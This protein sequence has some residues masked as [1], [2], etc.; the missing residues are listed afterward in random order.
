M[1]IRSSRVFCT[2]QQKEHTQVFCIA[3]VTVLL[4]MFKMYCF[5]H[6]D[7][8]VRHCQLATLKG[9]YNTHIL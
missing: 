4:K 2:L 6:K 8:Y 3:M 5:H 9:L 7:S 1:R